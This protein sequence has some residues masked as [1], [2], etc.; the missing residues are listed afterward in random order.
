M[1]PGNT[2]QQ[3]HSKEELELARVQK[4]KAE[5]LKLRKNYQWS[6]AAV[7]HR[8]CSGNA[9]RGRRRPVGPTD[10]QRHKATELIVKLSP[11]YT[12]NGGGVVW[13]KSTNTVVS[14][15]LNPNVHKDIGATIDF[16]RDELTHFLRLISDAVS[17]F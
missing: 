15:V 17:L 16:L 3:K 1:G 8:G 12:Q 6:I 5:S 13:V 9:P 4:V 10:A 2:Q 14:E 11:L 7:E